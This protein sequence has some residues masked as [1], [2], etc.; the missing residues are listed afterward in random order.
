LIHFVFC[1]VV[2]LPF[3]HAVTHSKPLLLLLQLPL[4]TGSDWMPG[5]GCP[6]LVEVS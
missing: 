4:N 6:L 2:P 1:I 5:F 3:Y